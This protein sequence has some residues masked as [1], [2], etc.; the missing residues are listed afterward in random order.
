MAPGLHKQPAGQQ[1]TA[2][3][4]IQH[5]VVLV[6]GSTLRLAGDA[7]QPHR[8]LR[9]HDSTLP[10]PEVLYSKHN[11]VTL[12]TSG[13]RPAR[14]LSLHQS[15]LA[16]AAPAAARLELADPTQQPAALH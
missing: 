15:P 2:L 10:L 5:R 14:W 11:E 4:W 8:A 12:R 16:G 7:R 1:V 9:L 3:S 13:W 6:V